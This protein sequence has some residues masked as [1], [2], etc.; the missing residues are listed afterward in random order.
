MGRSETRRPKAVHGFVDPTQPDEADRPPEL[1]LVRVPWSDG[2]IEVP[3]GVGRTVVVDRRV[4]SFHLPIRLVN[5][6]QAPHL[7]ERIHVVANPKIDTLV[8]SRL[9]TR[10][11]RRR[12]GSRPT[13]D[14]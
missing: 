2:R 8:G 7:P 10:P 9:P 1:Q 6:H 3:E 12:C 14:P 11:N 5:H 13:V 4:P